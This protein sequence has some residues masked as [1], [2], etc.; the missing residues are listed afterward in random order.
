M[1]ISVDGKDCFELTETQKKVICNDIHEDVFEADMKRRLQYILMHK[2]E[3]CFSRLKAEWE[4]KL[5]ANGIKAYPVDEDEFA[6][7]VFS[8]PNYKCRKDR[9]LE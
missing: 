1:R 2:Y 6:K 9:D 3:S 4:P 5:K 8:Q 7:L